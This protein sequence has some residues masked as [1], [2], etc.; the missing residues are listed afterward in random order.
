MLVGLVCLCA[1]MHCNSMHVCH[2]IRLTEWGMW[3]TSK[4]VTPLPEPQW[5]CRW[6]KTLV[7]HLS[8]YLQ[9]LSDFFLFPY[10]TT[11]LEHVREKSFCLTI[12]K[13]LASVRA[14]L[15]GGSRSAPV[16]PAA[17]PNLPSKADLRTKQVSCTQKSGCVLELRWRGG[18]SGYVSLE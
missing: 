8:I 17:S 9:A 5:W 2:G 11:F 15:A 16:T 14:V 18:S 4:S 10:G 7:V 12:M 6:N 13:W 3:G 1:Y